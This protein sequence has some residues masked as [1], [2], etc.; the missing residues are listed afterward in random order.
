MNKII[1]LA[2]TCSMLVACNLP[3]SPDLVT[4][5]PATES[6]ILAPE[7]ATPTNIPNCYFNWTTQPLPE[8]STQIQA[9]MDASGLTGVTA[10]A[11]AYG[12]NCYDYQTDKP[13]YFS[14][15]ETDFRITVEVK[16]LSD[17]AHLGD[18]LER[19]LVVLDGFPTEATPGPNPGYVGVTFHARDDDLRLWLTV[20]DGESARARG[21]DGTALLEALQNK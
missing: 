8:L 18:L 3:H 12:E 2:L 7:T 17:K 16:N 21:L 15:M 5:T 4:G 10:R 11:E 19:I 1:A 9:A 13:V 14:A 6:P 20:A